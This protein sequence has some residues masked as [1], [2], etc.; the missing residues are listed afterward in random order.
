MADNKIYTCGNRGNVNPINPGDAGV[1]IPV[2]VGQLNT[3]T[4]TITY[5][6]GTCYEKI[7]FSFS[8]TGDGSDGQAADVTL[9][10]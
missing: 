2:S 3:K 8:Q 7:Q 10:V 5:T 4:D 1:F 6:A 9:N